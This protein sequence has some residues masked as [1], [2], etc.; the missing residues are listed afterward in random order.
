MRS[1]SSLTITSLAR[2]EF[3]SALRRKERDGTLDATQRATLTVAFERHV[4]DG[5]IVPV[6]ASDAIMRA[7][8][9]LVDRYILRAYDAVTLATAIIARAAVGPTFLCFDDA[10]SAAARTEGFDVPVA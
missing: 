5:R 3:A 9:A 8:V 7:A 1:Y 6:G 10:L 2:V 4:A